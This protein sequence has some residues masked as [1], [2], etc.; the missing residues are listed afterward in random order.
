MKASTLKLKLKKKLSISN[1][2]SKTLH[3]NKIFFKLR[4]KNRKRYN[5]FSNFIHLCEIN[6][7]SAENTI[8]NYVQYKCEAGLYN[9]AFANVIDVNNERMTNQLK[10]SE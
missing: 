6:L 3:L 2:L 9:T 1:W 4:V 8:I 5:C 7:L 10:K